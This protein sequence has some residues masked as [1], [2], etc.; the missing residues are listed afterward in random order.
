VSSST[1]KGYERITNP[2]IRYSNMLPL[3]ETSAIPPAARVRVRPRR[4][5]CST[6]TSFLATAMK[7]ARRASEAS[8]S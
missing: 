3:Q 5:Q 8:K 1:V 6:G 7:L 2:G 4:N